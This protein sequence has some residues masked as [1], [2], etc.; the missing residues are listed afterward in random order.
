MGKQAPVYDIEEY[1]RRERAQGPAQSQPRPP[2]HSTDEGRK[3]DADEFADL[4]GHGPL[5]FD[6]LFPI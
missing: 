6:A 5:P 4:Q 2:V 1:L 3:N